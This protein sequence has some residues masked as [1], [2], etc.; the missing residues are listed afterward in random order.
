[1]SDNVTPLFK[2]DQELAEELG[3]ILESSPQVVDPESAAEEPEYHA[4]LKVW[5]HMLDPANQRRNSLPTA[6][7]CAIMVARWPFLKFADCTVVQREYFAIFDIGR[8]ILAQIKLD[9]AE[10]F[11][12]TS[13]DEDVENK[14]LYVFFLEEMQ[15]ALLVYQSEWSNED[16]EAGAKMAALGEAQQGLLGKDGLASYLGV[17]GLPYTEEEQAAMD[18]ELQAF[19]ESL[20][21]R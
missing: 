15:R 5:E 20:E 4:V 10:A 11:E 12:I 13:R 19:R 16:P 6:D 1:M 17:I 21:V 7:W 14:E 9:N 8:E 2:N 3:E 18:Q